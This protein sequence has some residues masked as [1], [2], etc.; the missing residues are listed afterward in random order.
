M[1][2]PVNTFPQA[3]L[4]VLH[5]SCRMV[6]EIPATSSLM[7]CF[8]IT[9]VLDF[10]S[11]ILLLSQLSLEE[12]VTCVEIGRSCRP[13]N[14]PSSWDHASWEHPVQDSQC[15]PLPLLA[16]SR[17]SGFQQQDSTNPVPEM[18]EASQCSG[19]N[20]LLLPCMPCLQRNRGQSPHKMLHHRKQ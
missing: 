5:H 18:C 17:E 14:I 4:E 13:F 12:E 19:Q 16:E 7:F 2:S 8:K 1:A 20:L 6:G 15:E 3:F 11:Y 9:V 10:F